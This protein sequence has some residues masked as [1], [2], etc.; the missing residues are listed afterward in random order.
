M[1]TPARNKLAGLTAGTA[2]ELAAALLERR[3]ALHGTARMDAGDGGGAG[4]GEP[5][6]GTG[7]PAGSSSSSSS[8]DTGPTFTQADVE[9]L[10]T[11]RLERERQAA[12]RRTQQATATERERIAALER[13]LSAER[14]A[15]TRATV[16]ARHNLGDL[17]DVLA[18]DTEEAL[19]NNAK[20]LAE[21]LKASTT[22]TSS[23]STR[24]RTV[25]PTVREQPNPAGTDKK[26]Q[27]L[28]ALRSL[29]GRSVSDG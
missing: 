2:H 23:T 15:R 19:E 18:G 3:R 12:D 6:G 9:R 29:S 1:F 20:R 28:E 13:D 14:L 17:G 24:T 10:I 26:A 11:A 22:S 5:A 8:A 4:T 7:D 21:R 25:R 27:A 16:A